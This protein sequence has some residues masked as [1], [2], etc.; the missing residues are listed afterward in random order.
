LKRSRLKPVGRR[1]AARRSAWAKTTALV[2]KRAGGRC[3]ACDVHH[4]AECTGRHDH[5]HHILPRGRGGP[6][7]PGN[8]LAVGYHHHEWI[9]GNP[10]AARALGFLRST[11][12]TEEHH[13]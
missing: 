8:A 9:H 5:T 12:T 3:E 2:R 6:D 7:T 13:P 4:L 1:G 11:T 10:A